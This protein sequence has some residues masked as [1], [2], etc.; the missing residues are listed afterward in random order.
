LTSSRI[1]GIE[2]AIEPS[3]QFVKRKEEADQG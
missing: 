2:P 1:P 3:G